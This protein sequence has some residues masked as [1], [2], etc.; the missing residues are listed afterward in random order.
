MILVTGGTGFIGQ[1]LIHQLTLLGKPVRTLLRPSPTSP[2]LP[3]GVPVEAAV[4]SF[5]DERGLRAALKDVDVIFHLAGNERSSSKADLTSTDVEGTRLLVR[6]AVDAGVERIFYVSHLGADRASAYAVLKAKALAEG[7]IV[8]SGL[9]YTI[10]RTAVVYGPGDQFTTSLAKLLRLSPGF[11][12]L[13]G[14]GSTLIQPIWIDDLITCMILSLEENIAQ[15]ETLSVGGGEYL[16]FNTVVAGIQAALG[17]RR[18][19]LFLPPPYLRMLALFME[20]VM[21]RFPVSIFWLDYLAADRTTAL[22]T[23][24]RIFGLIPARFHQHLDYLKPNQRN[25]QRRKK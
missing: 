16:S 2:N 19:E 15:N 9:D 20:Q 18:K 22:D 4:S 12:I 1:A 6:A 24:P 13:P 14:D 25:L 8:S 3:R 5:R 7:F 17:I 21:P 23:L 10:F 11:F